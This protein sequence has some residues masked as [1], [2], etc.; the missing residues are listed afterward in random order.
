MS[1][2]M[3]GIDHGIPLPPKQPRNREPGKRGR[4][5]YP[6]K[7][8]KVSDSF[9]FPHDMH[10]AARTIWDRR[11]FDP[12][13]YEARYVVENGLRIVRIWRVK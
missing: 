4:F 11:K 1:E 8:L 13:E 5:A 10:S 12:R 3:I 7:S 6:W 2:L 9:P